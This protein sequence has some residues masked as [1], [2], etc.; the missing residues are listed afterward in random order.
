MARIYN[1]S[2]YNQTRKRLAELNIDEDAISF[3]DKKGD[4]IVVKPK[5]IKEVIR[6]YF[7]EEMELYTD[8]TIINHKF[9]VITN[10][11]KKMDEFE[12]KME[13]HINDKIDSLT[14]RIME[15]IIS[16]VIEDEVTKRVDIKLKHI[17]DAL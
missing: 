2:D 10:V 15:T 17:K 12:H 4:L 11:N 14:E 6:E 5:E 7:N 9:Q 16:R 3:E 1:L 8:E 13:Q